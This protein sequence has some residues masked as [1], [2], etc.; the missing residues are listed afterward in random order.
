M[1]LLPALHGAHGDGTVSVAGETVHWGELASRAAALGRSMIG[2]PAVAVEA[3]PTLDTV[4]AITAALAAGVPAVPV[5]P[6]AG[7]V[8]REHI[9]RDS[10]ALPLPAPAAGFP[11]RPTIPPGRC[12]STSSH[13]K[14]LRPAPSMRAA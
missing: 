6:D 1:V 10:G 13:P 5:P 8:E 3:T 9:L 11:P 7:P 12:S 4:V 14:P 2:M